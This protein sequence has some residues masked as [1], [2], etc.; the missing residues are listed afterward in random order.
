MPGYCLARVVSGKQRS[1]RCL[2]FAG[3]LVIFPVF[4]AE[5]QNRHWREA[6]NTNLGEILSVF[7]SNQRILHRERLQ[8]AEGQHEFQF[9][10]TLGLKY[11]LLLQVYVSCSNSSNL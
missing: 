7:T 4:T 2:F 3:E 9:H 10:K 6:P 1:N 5:A 11:T 8:P